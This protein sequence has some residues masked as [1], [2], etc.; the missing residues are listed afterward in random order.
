MVWFWIW[1]GAQGADPLPPFSTLSGG[2][3]EIICERKCGYGSGP[4]PFGSGIPDPEP[5]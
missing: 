3:V 2:H 1:I 5:I 4:V